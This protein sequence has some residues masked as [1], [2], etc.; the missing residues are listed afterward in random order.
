MKI[1][2]L[3]QRLRKD[4]PMTTVTL[5]MPEDVVEDLKRIAP[6]LGFAGYQPL[7]RAYIGQGMRADLE[8]MESNPEVIALLDRLRKLGVNDEILNQAF[9]ETF[10]ALPAGVPN[11]PYI[12]KSYEYSTKASLNLAEEKATY[13]VE[14][15]SET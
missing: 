14:K 10:Y 12:H 2:D 5:R 6:L 4:R 11:Q 3:K 13:D 1:N 8:R 15:S 7:I 9:Q